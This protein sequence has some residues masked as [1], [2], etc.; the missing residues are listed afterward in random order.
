MSPILGIWASQMS[1]HLFAPSGAYDALATVTVPSGGASTI[2]FAGIPAGYKHL[3]IR[4][5]QLSSSPNNDIVMRF[6]GDSGSNYSLHVLQGNGASASAYAG[7]S[8][9]YATMGY[10]ADATQPA[11][12][13]CDI[14]DYANTSKYKTVRVLNGNDANGATRYM[15]FMSGNW[16]NTAAVTSITITHGAAVNFNEFSQFALYGVK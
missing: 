4:A 10:T 13:V 14:L 7:T 11:P 6:N 1:G 3:Q 15:N 9:T 16:R 5:I 12:S 8:S 2:T